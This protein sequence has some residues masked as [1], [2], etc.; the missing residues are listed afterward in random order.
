MNT[1]RRSESGFRK[2]RLAA[3]FGAALV[4]AAGFSSTGAAQDLT[5]LYS[6][7]GG[8]GANPSAGLIADPAGNLYG[9][10]AG[11]GA[12]GQGTVFQ[13][14]P[15]GNLTVLHSFTGA[16]GSYPRAVLIAD[17]AGN[18][19]GTTISGGAQD[20]GT[21]FQLTPSGT[22]NVLY[23]F[24]GGSDGALPWAGMIADAAGNLYGTTYSGGASGQG[25]VF[26]LDPSGTPTVLYSF[27]GGNDASPWAGLIADAAGNLYGTTE[28][29]DG[30]GEVFQ[31][32]PSGTLNVLCWFTGREGAVPHGGL[33]LD[34]A[35]NLYGTTHNGGTGGYG[36]VFQ[37]AP[38]G[39]LNV[40]HS[41]TGGSDGA[42]P[43]AGLVADTAGNL[44]G[45]TWGGGA[46]GQGTVFQFDPSGALN[47]LHSFTGGSDGGRPGADLIADAAGNL[48]G[49][50]VLGGANMT[51]PGGCGT[52][53]QLAAPASFV[54]GQARRYMATK[55]LPQGVPQIGRQ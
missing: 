19:Y 42:Y 37:L 50:T 52:V 51:C 6:F 28:G 8:D 35:G 46:G 7:T 44:Y 34:V 38:S 17:A 32:T 41:F 26:Q 49:T 18:L 48:Y 24:T 47:V 45:T 25:T 20:A 10:T 16:D 15:S 55:A 31:L 4:A 54:A 5:T 2:S 39:A 53:F 21:V 13:L 30:P 36:T 12:S 14:D 40:L 33:I 3:L 43:E 23:S 27:T 29:G 1:K 11:G 9:T 22:L